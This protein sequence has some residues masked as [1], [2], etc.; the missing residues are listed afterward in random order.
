M[1]KR[2]R[3]RGD[4]RR[5]RPFAVPKPSSSKNPQAPTLTKK[6]CRFLGGRLG[7]GLPKGCS[8][9]GGRGAG[10]CFSLLPGSWFSVRDA[11]E[12]GPKGSP[13]RGSRYLFPRSILQPRNR[14]GQK[15]G[16]GMDSGEKRGPGL[17]LFGD[18]SFAAPKPIRYQKE[19]CRSWGGGALSFEC[20]GGLLCLG[21]PL[22]VVG[23]WG[24]R[25]ARKRKRGWG[26]HPAPP[27][28]TLTRSRTVLA[29][30]GRRRRIPRRRSRR[31]DRR[32]THLEWA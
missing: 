9:G 31:Q 1:S 29:L 2:V 4:A 14:G 15:T 20:L 26:S 6:G 32:P 30:S 3:G 18:T 11:R 7:P 24:V 22:G 8:F 12:G 25:D 19:G 28:A 23:F 5:L 10:L 16:G 21:V 27:L 13:F 17:C